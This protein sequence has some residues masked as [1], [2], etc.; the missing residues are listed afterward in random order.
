[1]VE[2]ILA[3]RLVSIHNIRFLVRLTEQAHERIC[4]GTFGHW[5]KTWLDRYHRGHK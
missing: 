3:L 1:M 2:D 4:D 5:H